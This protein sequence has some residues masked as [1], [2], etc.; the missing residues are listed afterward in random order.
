VCDGSHRNSGSYGDF[1][2]GDCFDRNYRLSWDWQFLQCAN[3]GGGEV[4]QAKKNHR[5]R[6][7]REIA[8]DFAGDT[9]PVYSLFLRDLC[10]SLSYFRRRS[11]SKRDRRGFCR[12]HAPVYSL[13]LRDLCDS[14]SYFRREP[15]STSSR[16]P[17][18]TGAPLG[19]TAAATIIPCDSRP[20]ILRGTRLATMTTLRPIRVSGA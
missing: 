18:R 7:A 10:D 5:D 6:R 19:P 15:I 11:Q 2:I 3:L 16:N 13:F 4:G 14:L 1:G 9:L 8:E 20:R 12:R 17:A